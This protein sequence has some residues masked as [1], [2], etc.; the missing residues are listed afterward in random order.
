[1]NHCFESDLLNESV[2]RFTKPVYLLTL[3]ECFFFKINLYKLYE[4]YF[5]IM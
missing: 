4:I 1:M 5:I 3:L 2:V